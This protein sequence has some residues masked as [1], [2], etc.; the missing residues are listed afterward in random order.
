VC[1]RTNLTAYQLLNLGEAYF[2]LHRPMPGDSKVDPFVARCIPRL[3]EL[4]LYAPGQAQRIS[5]STRS[6][7][8]K[9]DDGLASLSS[10]E[11]DR[12]SDFSVESQDASL[13]AEGQEEDGF[14]TEV[15]VVEHHNTE[16]IPVMIQQSLLP[17]RTLNISAGSTRRN[18]RDSASMTPSGFLQI[19]ESSNVQSIDV[20]FTHAADVSQMPSDLSDAQVPSMTTARPSPFLRMVTNLMHAAPRDMETL[21]PS[22]ILEKVEESPQ[23]SSELA[24]ASKPPM[25]PS[26]VLSSS[27]TERL[28]DH[29]RP[30]M[31]GYLLFRSKTSLTGVKD[32]RESVDALKKGINDSMYAVEKVKST[33]PAF[34]QAALALRTMTYDSEHVIVEPAIEAPDAVTPTLQQIEEIQRWFLLAAQANLSTM[35]AGQFVFP[36]MTEGCD[37]RRSLGSASNGGRYTTGEANN[38]LRIATESNDGQ[39]PARLRRV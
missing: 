11:S 24:T 20:G 12:S 38:S 9:K 10:D 21:K 6:P 15:N 37:D 19:G 17:L 4:Q 27:G 35:S 33:K 5:F 1:Y 36:P 25:E 30:G 29:A 18:S 32:N 31:S 3:E 39:G 2:F 23:I 16:E 34:Q 22:A 28:G 26:N 8:G 14:R 13:E 7:R